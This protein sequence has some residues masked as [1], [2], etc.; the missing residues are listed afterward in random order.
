MCW[1]QVTAL[2]SQ[3]SPAHRWSLRLPPGAHGAQV[4]VCCPACFRVSLLFAMMLRSASPIDWNAFLEKDIVA[5]FVVF[6]NYQKD[7]AMFRDTLEK[8]MAALIRRRNT[9]ILLAMVF[10]RAPELS[11]QR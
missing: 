9:C 8:S 6:L 2:S 4:I 10:L 1:G 5:H 3:E 11:R 7:E